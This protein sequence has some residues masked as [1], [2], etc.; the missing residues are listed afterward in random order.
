MGLEEVNVQSDAGE[1]EALNKPTNA[2]MF[3]PNWDLLANGMLF[4]LKDHF[5]GNVT[6]Q[7]VFR[8]FFL[9]LLLD[10]IINVAKFNT[11]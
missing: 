9:E 2:L 1:G 8:F 4:L 11:A 10:N 3:F 7:K 6:L 5:K